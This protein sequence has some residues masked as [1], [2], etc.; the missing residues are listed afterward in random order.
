MTISEIDAVTCEVRIAATPEVVFGF[1]TDPHKMLRWM[2]T[3]AELDVRPGGAYWI[4][5]NGADVARGSFVELVPFSRI[6]LSWGWD[7]ADAPVPPGSTT[8]EVTLT[9]D[10]DG[11]HLRLVHRG[12]ALAQVRDAHRDGWQHYLE[13]L[14]IAAPGG[15][16]GPDPH[17]KTEGSSKQ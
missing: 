12:L 6:V 14:A 17:A 9:P 8:V 2:G 15:E 7:G 11:T 1:F 13:R 5:I 10:D 4:N 3:A 16:P